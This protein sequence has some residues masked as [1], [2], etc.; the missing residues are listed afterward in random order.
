M[1]Y[2]RGGRLTDYMKEKK[3]N[4]TEKR[5]A[6]IIYQIAMGVNIYINMELFTVI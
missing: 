5:A 6:E 2:I 4:F 1:E 3:F